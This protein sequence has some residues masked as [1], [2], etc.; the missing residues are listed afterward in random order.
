MEVELGD[1]TL[2]GHGAKDTLIGGVGNDIL[3]GGSG[4]DTLVF[5]PGFGNDTVTDFPNR[6][7]QES[8][9]ARPQRA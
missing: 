6:H 5:L 1:D 9:H 4:N 8:R 3:S 2:I 7:C